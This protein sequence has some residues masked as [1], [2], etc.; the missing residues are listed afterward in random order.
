MKRT[1]TSEKGLLE[2][3]GMTRAQ[4]KAKLLQLGKAGASRPQGALGALLALYTTEPQGI[5]P[6]ERFQKTFGLRDRGEG[7]GV[8][9][10]DV[11]RD[12]LVQSKPS[13][14]RKAFRRKYDKLAHDVYFWNDATCPGPC[15]QCDV[16]LGKEIKDKYL[17][18][19]KSLIRLLDL[20]KKQAKKGEPYSAKRRLAIL[21][22]REIV[23]KEIRQKAS[24]TQ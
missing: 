1:N 17:V 4:A 24:V 7:L 13:K 23:V 20:G 21:K 14:E 2:E 22:A 19:S 16:L 18:L 11:E 5:T 6:G 12:A 15:A 3:L 8:L 10:T 9:L